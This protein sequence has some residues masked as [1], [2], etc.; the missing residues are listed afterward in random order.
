MTKNSLF[1]V[2]CLIAVCCSLPGVSAQGLPPGNAKS[3]VET[4]CTT[5]HEVT[6]ITTAQHTH[7]DWQLLVE[8]M[9]SAGANIPKN[10][11]AMVVDYLAKGF[12]EKDVPKAV[13]VPGAVKV[14]F[15]EWK[16][17]TVGSR[18]HDP[19]ATHDGYL[20]YTGQYANVLGR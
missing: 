14:T 5:C 18:P 11:M 1:A 17:P 2:L 9:V 19:L 8:R 16:V 7:Q 12:P 15:K 10:Q 6:M 4:E 20:W 3:L 13:I